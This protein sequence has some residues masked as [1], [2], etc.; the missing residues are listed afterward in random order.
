MAGIIGIKIANGDFYFILQENPPLKKRLVLTTVHDGQK[1]VQ[2]DLFRSLSKSMLDAQYIGSMVVEDI[3]PLPKGEPSIEMVVSC[4]EEG[5]IAAD[6][7]DLD[8]GAGNE[9]HTLNV[10]LKTIGTASQ[11]DGFSGFDLG[12][13]QREAP[14]S[15]YS[16]EG[17]KKEEGRKFPW[18]I[19]GLATLVVAIAI[20]VLWF[21]LLGGKE[22][23][24]PSKP[25]A[26]LPPRQPPISQPERVEAPPPA[27]PERAEAPPVILAPTAPPPARPQ[28]VQQTRPA[29]PVASYSVPAVIPR[30]GVVYQIR[31]GDTLWDISAAF[32]RNP[33]L[34]PRIARYNNI[35]NP[36]HIIAGRNIRIPP[37]N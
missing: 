6:A 37:L 14:S 36:D 29:P 24:W 32:Y 1:N 8:I 35:S 10:S 18:I 5:N 2:I 15:L 26:Y 9:H 17:E 12:G 28:A 34:Y 30:N 11:E 22:R 27:Q 33:W 23:L 21:F 31:W 25:Y 7:Y 16:G 19:M 13:R 20:A 4:D 3:R